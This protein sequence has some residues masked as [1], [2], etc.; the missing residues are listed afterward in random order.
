MGLNYLSYVLVVEELAR[1]DESHSISTDPRS[2]S[3]MRA[4]AR[5]SGQRR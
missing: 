2:S 4:S 1:F 5:S 3:H